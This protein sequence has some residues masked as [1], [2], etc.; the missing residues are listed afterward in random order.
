MKQFEDENGLM[1]W[2][3]MGVVSYGPAECGMDGVPGVYTRVS[4]YV[5]WINN[6]I[7]S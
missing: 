1:S 6:T 3:V 4:S 7:E 5:D 2:Y